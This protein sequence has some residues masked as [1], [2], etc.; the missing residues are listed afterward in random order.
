MTDFEIVIKHRTDAQ[1]A[2]W[3]AER[4]LTDASF[5]GAS[6]QK[7]AKLRRAA[8]CAHAAHA[9]LDALVNELLGKTS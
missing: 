9:A 7:K 6:S 1:Y 8:E 3:R 2:M 4:A 5:A